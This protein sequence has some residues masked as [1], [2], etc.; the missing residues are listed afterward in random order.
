MNEMQTIRHE[1]IFAN[2]AWELVEKW[3][4]NLGRNSI[5]RQFANTRRL[6]SPL[7]C[8]AIQS[9]VII[10]HFRFAIANDLCNESTFCS[11]YSQFRQS[12]AIECLLSNC[13]AIIYMSAVG[14][15]IE[16]SEKSMITGTTVY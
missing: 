14:D 9:I 12:P 15:S 16:C 10:F 1:K 8:L 13:L 4:R 7:K 3:F 5:V 11:I 6:L 2:C